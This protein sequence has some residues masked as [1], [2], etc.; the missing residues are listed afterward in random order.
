VERQQEF[1]DQGPQALK[2]LRMS[3]LARDQNCDPSTISRTVADKYL[4]SPRGIFALR[5]FFV[6]GTE[7]PSGET[8]SWDSV[9]SRVKEL[10][11]REDKHDPMSDDLVAETLHKEG[12]NIS[13]RTVAKYRQQLNI[14][15][16]RQ[17]KAY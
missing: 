1:F 6:G 2:I 9:K 11:D 10:V 14:P 7:S 12:I 3:D 15:T 13:R 17:R 16:A 8:A 5:D 4:Q